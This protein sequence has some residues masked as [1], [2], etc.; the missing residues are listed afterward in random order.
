[1]KPNLSTIPTNPGCYLY[2]DET[3]KVIYV[4][5]AK[6]LKKRVSSYFTKKDLD[7]KTKA[8]VE[9]IFEVKF[10]ITNTET[11]AFL[12]ENTLIKKYN[13]K[14]NID[15]KDSKRYAYIELTKEEIPKFIVARQKEKDKILFGPFTDAQKRDSIL[16]LI[17]R[18]FKLRTCKKLPKKACLRYH[19]GFCVAPCINKISKTDYLKDIESGKMILLGEISKLKKILIENMKVESKKENFE[20]ALKIKNQLESLDYLNE[21]QNVERNKKYDEDIINYL[22]L[23]D[24]I[25]LMLFNIHNG[26]LENKQEFEFDYKVDFLEEFLTRYYSMNQIPKKIIV[27][28]SLDESLS[29]FLSIKNKSKVEVIFPKQGELKQ[30]LELVKKN[31]EIQYFGDKEKLNELKEKLNLEEIPTT[32]E[33]FDISHLSGTNTVASMIQ[34]VNGK[35]NKN[36]YRKFN[37]K[38]VEGID[39]F[40]SMGEVVKRRYFRLKQENKPFPNLILI[41]GGEIQLNFALASLNELNIKIPI[42]ALAKREEEI[43]LPSENTPI[44]L[45]K[46]NKGLL[47][48]MQIRD[49]AHRFAISFQRQKRG[50]KIRE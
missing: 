8:L 7:P 49:E 15:L 27:P 3:K 21:K 11:E 35:P 2:L 41:D 28:E 46:K 13:P 50:K 5:K 42:I 6:N 44:K 31:L 26:C 40:A 14:Y 9:N 34:F 16:K 38:S 25:H 45:D 30:L 12:L 32:I 39:D 29:E 17:N 22:I 37:I 33:C 43:Y 48:L 47:L 36:E 19:L 1:M 4:G 24:K 23:E 10:F 18:I 20:E